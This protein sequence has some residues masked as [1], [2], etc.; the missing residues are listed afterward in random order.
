MA[1]V[2]LSQKSWLKILKGTLHMTESDRSG[3]LKSLLMIDKLLWKWA[4][5][6][7]S[8]IFI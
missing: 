5:D 8:A 7:R 3:S 4:D 6:S 2:V 1:Q